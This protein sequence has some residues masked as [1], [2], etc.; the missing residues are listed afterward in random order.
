MGHRHSCVKFP[1]AML[2]PHWRNPRMHSRQLEPKQWRPEHAL[3]PRL[4]ALATRLH[5]ARPAAAAAAVDEHRPVVL[6]AF[7]A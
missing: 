5:A 1:T 6:N 7:E 2:Q 3:R 4:P